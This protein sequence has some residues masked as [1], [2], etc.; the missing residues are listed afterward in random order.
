MDTV[1]HTF[2]DQI[3]ECH[4]KLATLCIFGYVKFPISHFFIENSAYWNHPRA[5]WVRAPKHANRM[6]AGPYGQQVRFGGNYFLVELAIKR[7]ASTVGDLL[8]RFEN[9]N[10]Y[11]YE[12]LVRKLYL[13]VRGS[14]ANNDGNE[15][16]GYYPISGNDLVFGTQS[17]DVKDFVGIVTATS[18]VAHLYKYR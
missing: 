12:D 10:E 5:G 17:I 13:D 4:A 1:A 3:N 9:G 6:V 15:Y 2:E 7:C 11:P 18:K 14:V 16:Q 8:R